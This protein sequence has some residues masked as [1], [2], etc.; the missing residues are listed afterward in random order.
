MPTPAQK[1]IHWA[2]LLD[3][4]RVVLDLAYVDYEHGYRYMP[5]T[6]EGLRMARRL[7]DMG[8]LEDFGMG[9]YA[10]TGPKPEGV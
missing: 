8:F 6:P 4:E 1:P 3:H 7:V 5:M 2:Q 10:P 9:E